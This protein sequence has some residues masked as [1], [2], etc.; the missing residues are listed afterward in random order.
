MFDVKTA[1]HGELF[2]HFS[3]I[4]RGDD[5]AVVRGK[6]DP[7]IFQVRGADKQRPMSWLR[8]MSAMHIVLNYNAR[9]IRM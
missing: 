1:N 4:I 3:H 6:P 2:A 7:L 9:V 8:T 5:P